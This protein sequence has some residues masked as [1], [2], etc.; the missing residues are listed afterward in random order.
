[1]LDVVVVCSPLLS[2]SGELDV[3]PSE[4]RCSRETEVGPETSK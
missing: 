2:R 4:L 3:L 1:M